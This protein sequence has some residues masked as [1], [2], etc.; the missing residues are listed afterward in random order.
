MKK[1]FLSLALILSISPAAVNAATFSDVSA[2]HWASP[3]IQ[4]LAGSNLVAGYKDGTFKPLQPVTKGQA[5][6]IL[7]RF[8]GSADAAAFRSSTP[9][10]QLTRAEAAQIVTEAFGIESVSAQQSFTDVPVSHAAHDAIA[11]A[12]GAGIINGDE[13]KTFSPDGNVSRAFFTVILTRAMNYDGVPV[14]PV[15]AKEAAPAETKE[16]AAPS[17]TEVQKTIALVN[18]ER[19]KAGNDAVQEEAELSRIAQAKAEDMAKLGYFE[20]NSPTYGTPFDMAYE[21]DYSYHMFGENIAVGY[22]S[23]ESVMGGWMDSESHR[24]NLLKSGYTFIGVGYAE[25]ETGTPYWVH[26]FSRK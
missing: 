13:A 23:A 20:H 21:F 18:K 25:D 12:A 26:M 15:E 6:A 19:E 10:A 24:E 2:D 22:T 4:Q 8:D 1:T 7:A 3:A 14:T 16:T 5:A 17:A 9:D 11:A